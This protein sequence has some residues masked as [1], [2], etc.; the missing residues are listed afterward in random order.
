MASLEH[1][2]PITTSTVFDIASVSKQFG[3][4]SIAMLAHEGRLSLDDDVH[5]Y[6]PE[7]ADFGKPL[8]IRHLVH[9][10]SGIRD[11]PGTLAVGGWRMDD[12]ISFDQILRMAWKQQDLNFEP[13]AEYLYSNTGYNLLAETVA[14]VTGEP[15][16]AWTAKHLF[17]PLGM[18]DTHF[19]GDHQRLVKNRAQAYSPFDGSYLSIPN[20]LTALASSS[21]FTTVD[22]LVKWV[23]NFEDGRVGG[24][25]VLAQM[26]QQGVLND[27]EQIAYA[28]GNSIGTYRGLRTVSHSGSWAGFRTY[29]VRFPEQRFAVIVLSNVS[30]FNAGGRANSIADVYLADA[31]PEDDTDPSPAA[32]TSVAVDP[33]VLDAYV[34]TY[35]LGPGWYVTITREGDRLLAQATNEPRFDMTPVSDTRFWVQ[36]YGA[37]IDFRRDASGRA[38]HFDYRGMEAPRVELIAPEDVT[39]ADF[40]GTYYSDELETTYTAVDEDGALVLH[41]LRHGPITLRPTTRDTFEGDAWFMGEVVFTRDGGGRV[42][43][44]HASNGRSRRLR[45]HRRE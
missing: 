35:K 31:F 27:G 23:L 45:F 21:L 29:L 43:G 24:P 42:D 37:H 20:V 4:M 5:T 25:E 36:A 34:G 18:A 7:L 12:V 19:Q 15:F 2:I 9:H 41:H 13:G 26:H 14:R 8:T 32:G 10:T 1:G 6:L 38:G 11:W 44:F 17:E 28:F 39:P 30:N 3:A 22:D 40:T 33:A 16:P